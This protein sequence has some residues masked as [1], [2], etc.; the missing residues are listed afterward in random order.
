MDH[1][2][3]FDDEQVMRAIFAGLDILVQDERGEWFV[4]AYHSGSAID[5][6]GLIVDAPAVLD[7]EGGIITGPTYVDGWHVNWRG[8]LPE[9]LELYEIQTPATPARVWA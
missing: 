1:Y 6:V 8:D 7:E 3:K 4:P 9:E 5:V 2:L